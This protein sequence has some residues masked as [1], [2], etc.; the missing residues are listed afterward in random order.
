[1]RNV[2]IQSLL[3]LLAGLTLALPLRAAAP[4]E[5]TAQAGEGIYSLLKRN[6]LSPEQYKEAFIKL[7]KDNLGPK[8]TLYKGRT[9]KLPGPGGPPT[10]TEPL[11]GKKLQTVEILNQRLKGAAFYLVSGHGGPD[12]GAIGKHG[13]QTLYEDEYAYDVTLRLARRL[14]EH[15]AKVHII[16]RDPRSGIRDEKY[17]YG[18]KAEVCYP[19]QRIPLNQKARLRQRASAVNLLCRR[20]KEFNYKR[21]VVI[22]V[23]SRAHEKID[24]F[25]YHHAG[26]KTGKKAAEIMRDTVEEKY[27]INQ[28][29]RGYTGD[30]TSRGLFMLTATDPPTVFIELGNIQ[31]KRDQI[32]LIEANNRQ[33]LANWLCEGLLRDAEEN[34]PAD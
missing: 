27:R 22:H 26:S 12:P 29:G 18:S 25:F 33:A 32:R 1:M 7:N 23:D 3:L 13:R 15:G 10:I 5:V 4:I 21:C 9:Y 2:V 31:H 6:G 11:F 30:V 34:R 14:M 17:L 16:I 28:P 20:D 19:N 8:N 24:I